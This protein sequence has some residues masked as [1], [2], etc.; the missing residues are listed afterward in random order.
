MVTPTKL[1]ELDNF[2]G[3]NLDQQPRKS[4]WLLTVPVLCFIAAM[5]DDNVAV[6]IN[7]RRPA[8]ERRVSTPTGAISRC[9]DAGDTRDADVVRPLYS[10]PAIT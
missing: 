8:T 1:L 9:Q 7:L 4:H 5:A 3:I 2:V 10:F 6:Q